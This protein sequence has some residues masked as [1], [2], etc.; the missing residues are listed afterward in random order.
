MSSLPPVELLTCSEIYEL[1][2]QFNTENDD[3]FSE[4]TL[5]SIYYNILILKTHVRNAYVCDMNN[6]TKINT[7]LIDFFQVKM[8]FMTDKNIFSNQWFMCFLPSKQKWIDEI[9]LDDTLEDNTRIGLVLGFPTAGNIKEYAMNPERYRWDVRVR[10]TKHSKDGYLIQDKNTSITAGVGIHQEDIQKLY[11]WTTK[12]YDALY[13]LDSGT[14]VY[15]TIYPR[16][17]Y[18]Y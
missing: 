18:Y 2:K 13:T 3:H 5:M 9:L 15:L 12:M 7:K 16:S 14:H 1:L 4:P 17:N 11:E 10:Y 6:N 8:G